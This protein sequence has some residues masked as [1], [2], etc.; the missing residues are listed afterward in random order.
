MAGLPH[1]ATYTGRLYVRPVGRGI[2]LEELE[3]NPHVDEWLE[4]ILATAGVLDAGD[5]WRG[6]GR[7]TQPLR[8]RVT[9]ES[10]SA[11]E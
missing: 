3:G 11:Q 6:S 5:M 10:V 9:V 4:S 2:M 7:T 8:L 1:T